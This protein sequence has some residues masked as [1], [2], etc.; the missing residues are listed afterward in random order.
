[1]AALK[2]EEG[3]LKSAFQRELE[4]QLPEFV[5]LRYATA[6]APD[7]EIVGNNFVSHFE[8]K[9][10]TPAFRSPGLQELTMCRLAVVGHA[11][12]VIWRETPHGG[13]STMIVHPLIVHNRTDWDL[14]PEAVTI[15][16]DHRWLVDQI[17]Q[18]H[19]L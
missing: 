7:R 16:F 4:R 15:G 14:Q 11:R 12:Y 9:H 17:K 19:G 5:T 18:V 13:K 8:F 2:K 3:K 6:G 10:G 1:M